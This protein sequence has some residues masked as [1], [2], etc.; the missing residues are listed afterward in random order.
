MGTNNIIIL[1]AGESGVGAA[2]LARKKGFDVFVSDNNRIKEKYKD[3]LSHFDIEFE[4]GKHSENR[5][6]QATE[7]IKSPGIPDQVPLAKKI[8]K[9]GI[10][11]ISEIEFAARFT[12]AKLICITGSNGK[13]TTTLLTHHILKKAGLDVAVAG[14]VGNSFA[15]ELAKQDHG[16][17]VLE[18]SSFQLDGMFSFKADIAILL[19]ITPDHLDR[20]NYSFD[21]YAAS[22]FRILRNMENEDA[23]IYCMDDRVISKKIREDQVSP[24]IIPFSINNVIEGEGACLKDNNIIINIQSNKQIMTLES[25]AL[26]GKHN[27]YNSMAAAIAGRLLDIRKNH[28]QESLS[29]FQNIEHRLEHVAII[30]G[31]EFIND[32]KATNI[33][34]AWYALESMQKEVIWIAGGIDKGNDYSMLFDLVKSKVKA[35]V[36]LGKDNEHIR[37]AFSDIVETIIETRSMD[38]AVQTALYLGKKG[39]CILLSPACASFDLFEN[40]EDRGNQFKEAINGL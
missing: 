38:V 36:C 27:I 31:M 28:I 22:K 23:F 21:D 32:S 15:M 16:Y 17:F 12:G 26:Q 9:K 40:F 37:N 19:N 8:T 30:Q 6:L 11:I 1:G 24:R 39:D 13:T 14:N 4:E 35:I 7:V 3:V 20:Y 2:V 5:I 33:N 34:A 18:I 10:P 29:D 25:L